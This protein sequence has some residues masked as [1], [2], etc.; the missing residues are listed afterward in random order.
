MEDLPKHLLRAALRRMG[1]RLSRI[2]AGT[3]A[4]TLVGGSDWEHLYYQA[5]E[6]FK[7]SE[8][9]RD[10]HRQDAAEIEALYRRFLFTD[11]P[12]REG[13]SR[14]L[15][16]L[17]GTTVSEAIY[18]IKN[19]HDGLKIDGDICEFGVAQGA[20]SALLAY[21]IRN[22][23]KNIWLYDSFQGLPKPTVKDQLKDDI[24]QL[25]SMAAY[26]GTMACPIEMVQA[27]LMEIGFPIS[28]TRI[29]PGFIESTWLGKRNLPSR[30]AFAYVDFDLYSPI[31]FTLNLLDQILV[32]QGFIIVDDYDFF[33][34]G[35]KAA[36]DEFIATKRDQ[37]FFGLPV[38]SAGHFCV[39]QKL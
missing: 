2:P 27:R 31:L 17:I 38:S 28:R 1:Y 22:T 18:V 14:D 13:R 11:L 30:V 20:T 6:Q 32:N 35:A 29:I 9:M 33:S 10:I 12:P 21:E 26:E 25:G 37:Y 24:F 36:V 8:A 23:D 34:T 7:M 15:S 16:D 4:A 19:L 3:A 39:I 5:L